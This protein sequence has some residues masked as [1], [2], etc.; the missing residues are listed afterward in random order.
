M[1]TVDK[2]CV[3]EYVWSNDGMVLLCVAVLEE[4]K[5]GTIRRRNHGHLCVAADQQQQVDSIRMYFACRVCC[6]DNHNMGTGK[7]QCCGSKAHKSIGVNDS[8]TFQRGKF[9]KILIDSASNQDQEE[10]YSYSKFQSK[11]N[12]QSTTS[13]PKRQICSNSAP[14]EVRNLKPHKLVKNLK[15]LKVVKVPS[16]QRHPKHMNTGY[17]PPEFNST[18]VQL[19]KKAQVGFIKFGRKLIHLKGSNNIYYAQGLMVWLGLHVWCPNLEEDLA[20]LYNTPSLASKTFLPP[21]C[22]ARKEFAIVKK[23]PK[24]YQDILA[25][26]GAQ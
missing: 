1:Y 16:P 17:F 6:G 7:S 3:G 23:F 11:A 12:H 19:F 10:I 20:S 8:L 21:L 14:P 4:R 24:R 25:H 18:K 2:V 13:T 26:I 15:S 5:E 22:D 9:S